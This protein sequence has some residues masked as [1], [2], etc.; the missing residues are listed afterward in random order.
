MA[1]AQYILYVARQHGNANVYCHGSQACISQLEGAASI[2]H[3]QDIDILAEHEELPPWLNG[4]PLLVDTK[5]SDKFRGTEAVEVIRKLVSD[6]RSAH[7]AA[8]GSSSVANYARTQPPNVTRDAKVTEDDLQ[9][10]IEMR[11]NGSAARQ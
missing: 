8:R 2:A 4:S 10:Y 11:N 5:T 9:R 3:I 6:T 1:D 7:V